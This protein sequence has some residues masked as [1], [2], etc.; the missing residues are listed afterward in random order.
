M[1]FLSNLGC[2]QGRLSPMINNKIQCFPSRHWKDEFLHANSL[3][4]KFIEWTLDYNK[5]FTN[6]IFIKKKVKL[7]LKLSKKYSVRIISLTGDCFMQ[8]PFWKKK[9]HTSNVS[10]L[11]KIITACSKL[12]IRFIVV[13]LVDNGSLEQP[14]HEKKLII[15]FNNLVDFLKKKKIIILFESD[16]PPKKLKNFIEKFNPDFFGI[17][18]DTGNSAALGFDVKKE[19]YY[20]GNYIKG[21][22]IKDRIFKGETVRLGSGNVNFKLL[23]KLLKK[24]KYKNHII[25]QTARSK[26]NN[27]IQEIKINLR[28]IFKTLKNN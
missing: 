8:N 2:M 20:Y 10:D 5:I 28:Y 3:G 23:F 18:Y 9:N 6:P 27:D 4:L 13:P 22:H 17:N 11:K 16:Y 24:I 26:D 14:W 19:F 21:V 15:I 1:K 25:F 12:G 7:I